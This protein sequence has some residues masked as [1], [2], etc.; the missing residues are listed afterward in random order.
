MRIAITIA[1]TRAGKWETLALPDVAIDAQ[2]KDVKELIV[3]GSDKYDQVLILTSSGQVKRARL[4]GLPP[5][6]PK[7]KV[8]K[9]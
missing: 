3:K 9:K 6:A 2:K 5:P 1:K 8:V 7:K 4:K